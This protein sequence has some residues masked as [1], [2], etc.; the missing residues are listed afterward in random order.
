MIEIRTAPG[1]PAVGCIRIE[2]GQYRLFEVKGKQLELL[3]L[4]GAL[5]EAKTWAER[6]WGSGR[7]PI[8][9][10]TAANWVRRTTHKVRLDI[11]APLSNR[12]QRLNSA[13]GKNNIFLEVRWN[14]VL[15]SVR[16]RKTSC[17]DPSI[18]LEKLM[19]EDCHLPRDIPKFLLVL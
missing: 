11:R 10:P 18:G 1:T 17:K 8:L 6:V 5:G 16:I 7:L 14:E 3:G 19:V 15:G 4:F 9:H 2:A 13:S 12:W